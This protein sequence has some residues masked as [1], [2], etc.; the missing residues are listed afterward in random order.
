MSRHGLQQGPAS[1]KA[2]DAAILVCLVIAGLAY[3]G[4]YYDCGFN[5]G[6]EGSIVLISARL[7]DGE[8]PFVDVVLGYGLLWCYPLVLLF[9]I[10]GVSF[11]AARIYFLALALMTSLLAFL[12]VRRHTGRRGLATGR[13]VAKDG[14]FLRCRCRLPRRADFPSKPLCCAGSPRLNRRA[15]RAPV[16]R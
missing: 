13:N 1:W 6:D 3:F 11:I 4:Q 2:A 7:L 14:G 15:G 10:T 16:A 8:R 5:V 12:T 9:E